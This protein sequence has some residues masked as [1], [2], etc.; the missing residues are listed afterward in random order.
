MG[1]VQ[2]L[3]ERWRMAH[4]WPKSL[5]PQQKQEMESWPVFSDRRSTL[6]AKYMIQKKVIFPFGLTY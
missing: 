5:F 4:Y 6:T 1:L 3:N 2:D